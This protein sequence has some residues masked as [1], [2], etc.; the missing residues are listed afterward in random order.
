[1]K[2]LF[3]IGVCCLSVALFMGG[4]HCG[5]RSVLPPL[6]DTV[7]VTDSFFLPGPEIV[8][9]VPVP[10]PADVDTAAI[11]AAHYTK[12]IYSDSLV[13]T[14]SLKV[15]V[16]DTVYRN[17]L[18][19]RKVAYQMFRPVYDNAF[20]IGVEVAPQAVCLLGGYQYKNW[21]WSAGY[22]FY[23]DAPVLGVK[24]DLWRW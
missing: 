11:L 21:H 13:S 7:T 16:V 19:G 14:P 5:R 3:W 24:Y 18:I 6:P 23:N 15:T 12:R 4:F 22:D 9:E 2:R 8:R 20:S 17:Q 10:V 1:M